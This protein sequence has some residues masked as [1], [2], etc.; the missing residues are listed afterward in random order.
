MNKEIEEII[1]KVNDSKYIID[2]QLIQELW[3]GYG[4]L[5]RVKLDNCTVILKLIKFPDDVVHPRGWNSNLSHQRKVNSYNFEKNWYK[6]YNLQ[7]E[8]SYTP[9]LIASGEIEQLQY[10]I[11]EDLQ[12]LSFYPQVEI[13]NTQVKLTLKWLA[14]FHAKYL[15]SPTKGLWT[16]G[17]Y[18]NLETRPDEFNEIKDQALKE[19]APLIDLKLNTAKYKTL[20]HGDAKLANFLYNDN[21]QCAAVDFQYVGGGVGIKDVAYFFSSIYQ[22]DE[23]AKKDKVL[24]DYYFL[25]L[26]N[27]LSKFGHENQLDEIEKEW[28]ELYN[29]AWSDFYRFLVGWSPSHQKINSYSKEITKKVLKCI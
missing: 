5:N 19:A 23:L 17:T 26:R 15:N 24:L 4:S 28:R 13:S 29:Y 20:V 22:E 18:W 6:K 25:E 1:L 27:A 10:L 8:Q 11:L 9:R 3:S 12:D 14:Y 7:I 16:I 2:T 21:N